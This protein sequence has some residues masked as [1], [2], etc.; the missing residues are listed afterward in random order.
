M[1]FD[2]VS[3]I[4]SLSS[5]LCSSPEL[6]L[7]ESYSA[8][9]SSTVTISSYHSPLLDHV[10]VKYSFLSLTEPSHIYSYSTRVNI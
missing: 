6:S 8:S 3:E 7:V 1:S 2:F 5:V 9:L 4:S 10:D